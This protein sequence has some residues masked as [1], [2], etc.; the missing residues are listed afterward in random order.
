MG[1]S[2]EYRQFAEA[3]LVMAQT[4]ADEVARAM[5]IQMARVWHRLA[6]AH[7]YETE[8]EGN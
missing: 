3:C 5:L 8:D 7:A 2:E 1:K 4:A 6:D